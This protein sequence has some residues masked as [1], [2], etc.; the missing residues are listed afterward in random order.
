MWCKY[1]NNVF[2][3]NFYRVTIYNYYSITVIFKTFPI[4]WCENRYIWLASLSECFAHFRCTLWFILFVH[5]CEMPHIPCLMDS[6]FAWITTFLYFNIKWL[7]NP[8]NTKTLK[9]VKVCVNS[10]KVSFWIDTYHLYLSFFS[11]LLCAAHA[12]LQSKELL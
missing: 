4:S 6:H 1:I 2:A 3:N 12:L 8:Q 9:N 5:V 10:F 7:L 11:I